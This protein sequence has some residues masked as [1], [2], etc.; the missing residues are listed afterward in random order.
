MLFGGTP[1][2]NGR[3]TRP[4]TKL[5]KGQVLEVAADLRNTTHMKSQPNAEIPTLY[6][7]PHI[8]VDLGPRVTPALIDS[9]ATRSVIRQD[10]LDELLK[11][12]LVKRDQSV[13]ITCT[14]ATKQSL[15]ITRCATIK[16]KIGNYSWNV[17]LLVARKLEPQLIL[18]IDFIKKTSLIL[19]VHANQFHFKFDKHKVYQLVSEKHSDPE[20]LEHLHSIKD[21]ICD[22][23]HLSHK[24]QNNLRELLQNFDSVLTSKLGLTNLI[25][26]RIKL[27]DPSVVRLHPYKLTPPKMEEMRKQIDKL[28]D[29]KVIEPSTSAYSSPAFLVP[30]SSGKHRLVVD[31]RQLNKRIE[32]EAVPLPDIHGAFHY[33]TNAK[34]FTIMDLNQA[35]H[36]IPLAEESKQLTAFCV[37]FNLY[38]FTRVPFG[39]SQGSSVCS[40]LLEMIFHDIKFKYVY[41]YLDDIVIYSTSMDEHLNHLREVLHRLKKANLTVNPGKV[42]FAVTEFPFLGHIVTADGK[43]SID[44]ERT[45]AIREFAPP[46]DAKGIARFLGMVNYFQKYIPKF[47]DIASPLNSLRKK[48]TKFAWNSETQQSFEK[49]KECI[50]QPPILQMADFDKEFIIQTDSSSVA[51]GAVIYQIVNENRLPISYASRTLTEQERKY[52]AYEL[53]CLAIIFAFEKFKPFIE[54]KEFMLETDNQALSWLLNHPKQLGRIGRWVL[55]LNCYNFQV[56]HIRG[57]KNVVADTLSRRYPLP[58]REYSTDN[59]PP[60]GERLNTLITDFPLAFTSITEYQRQD[61]KLK[62]IIGELEKGNT[63]PKYVMKKRVLCYKRKNRNDIRIIAPDVI[64]PMLIE[65]YHS[66]PIG[67]HLGVS[68]TLNKI[69]REYTWENMNNEIIKHIRNCEPCNR[70]KPAKNMRIGKAIS[71]IP[72]RPFEKISIDFSGPYPRSKAGNTMLLICVDTF[73]KFV[74]LYPLRQALASTTIKTLQERLFKDFGTPEN[75]ISDNGPQFRSKIFKSMCFNNCI[76]HITVTEYRPQG[77]L[78]ERYLRNLKAALIAYH[79]QE[80]TS[81]DRNL[82]WIQFAFNTSKHEGHK[83]TPFQLLFTYEPNH[84]LSNKWH[85][86]D[87]LSDNVNPKD[88]REIWNTARLNLKQNINKSSQYYDRNR[89]DSPYKVNDL[90]MYRNHPQS[91]KIAK[92]TAKLCYKWDGPYKIDEY[93]TP[94]TVTLHDPKT[95]K[96][97]RR[98]HVSQIKPYHGDISDVKDEQI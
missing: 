65:Y 61:P 67:A 53:E 63:S 96:Y 23:N 71:E 1:S 54:H 40:R 69:R 32:F 24:D 22:L 62:T 48:G 59:P 57:T 5:Q 46:K 93:L 76:N 28:L 66:S 19:D 95:G 79:G 38:Q 41:H 84:P 55:R 70:S 73:T 56:K 45:R 29:Q 9:G 31:Y 18:G 16:M 60:H 43:V 68:K 82:P 97:V 15:S 33:F 49:L 2:R 26:Y 88:I 86:R 91:S 42:K 64:K 25:E 21:E 74:W 12:K 77:N 3:H 6:E 80:H 4:V 10:L 87:L 35:F 81:W 17:P 90:V 92:S 94:V 14:T 83:F 30:K 13:N 8:E 47:A 36:Q 50:I 85:I 44:P 52:S 89:K 72:S 51:L 78:A 39:I 34:V 75:L 7:L 37:P 27:K 58:D 11:H 20:P 98:S